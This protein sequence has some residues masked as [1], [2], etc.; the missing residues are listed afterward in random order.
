ML[1]VSHRYLVQYWQRYDDQ[2]STIDRHYNF[3]KDTGENT[4]YSGEMSKGS[5]KRLQ[6]AC[7][8]M[9]A[10]TQKKTFISKKD[11]RKI[12]YRIGLITLTLSAPQQE[13]T[14]AQIKKEMLEPY[15]RKLKKYG[16][17]NYIWK[18][19]RQEN[20]NLHFHIFID[21]FVPKED[22]T[23]IWNRLQSKFHFIKAYQSKY[24]LKE[25]P[26]TNIKVVK[27]KD[28]MIRYMLKYM[29]KPVAK[30]EQLEFGRP[31]DPKHKGK[32]WDCS[33]ALKLNNPTAGEAT[34]SEWESVSKAVEDGFLKE[35]PKD[36]ATIYFYTTQKSVY[37][38]PNSLK[39]RYF[40]YLRAV[41]DSSAPPK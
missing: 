39:E 15:L 16:L 28:G 10:V 25:A 27:S 7:E 30:G 36:H 23:N 4:T 2:D 31:T 35:V 37:H 17:K 5:I 38:L 40:S 32:T 13:I 1:K 3:F 12:T 26:S 8:L 24:G 33:K 20:G 41:R 9:N 29:I 34:E 11:G 19:E 14:D 21:C 22:V 6:N 18:A